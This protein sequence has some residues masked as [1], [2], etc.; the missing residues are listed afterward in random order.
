MFKVITTVNTVVKNGDIYFEDEKIMLKIEIR[1]HVSRKKN[2]K[3]SK[4]R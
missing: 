1:S 4:N 2:E 3:T